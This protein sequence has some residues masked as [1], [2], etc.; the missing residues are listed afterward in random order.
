VAVCCD[1]IDTDLY[2]YV[3]LTAAPCVDVLR[4]CPH[5]HTIVARAGACCLRLMHP[6]HCLCSRAV[7]ARR[8][9]LRAME[10]CL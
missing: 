4:V 6:F 5:Y 1:G 8:K 10:V 2:K 9:W 7:V 3:A